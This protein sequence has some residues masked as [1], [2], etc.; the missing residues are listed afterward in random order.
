MA[1]IH[2]GRYALAVPGSGLTVVSMEG[3]AV[4]M[5]GSCT[6][7]K[8][9]QRES[10]PAI[11]DEPAVLQAEDS[12]KEKLL[13]EGAVL[14]ALAGVAAAVEVTEGAALAP[15]VCALGGVAIGAGA[16]AAGTR[17]SGSQT[18]YDRIREADPGN[19]MTGGGTGYAAG[20]SVYG[21][22]A[23]VPAMSTITGTQSG[24]M[25][26]TPDFTADAV[27]G[28]T[29]TEGY[30][31]AI[32]I[33]VYTA[34]DIDSSHSGYDV[35]LDK[36]FNK[37]ADAYEAA[38]M[39][40]DMSVRDYT[41]FG[42]R[43]PDPG[44][45]KNNSD[46]EGMLLERLSDP[47]GDENKDKKEEKKYGEIKAGRSVGK[48]NRL[49]KIFDTWRANNKGP[50][51]QDNGSAG[52]N[53]VFS[54]GSED[55][56]YSD[57]AAVTAPGSATD[58]IF[59]QST[60]N[61]DKTKFPDIYVYDGLPWKPDSNTYFFDLRKARE[62][63]WPLYEK[64]GASKGMLSSMLMS[65][66]VSTKQSKEVTY[67]GQYAA[68]IDGI[69][70]LGVGVWPA[71]WKN[72]YPEEALKTI[73]MDDI[74]A[75]WTYKMAIVVVDKGEDASDPSK[76]KYVPATRISSKADTFYGC[77]LQTNVTLDK[78]EIILSKSDSGWKDKI[79]VENVSSYGSDEA[80]IV[81]MLKDIMAKGG[82]LGDWWLHYV[83]TYNIK[84]NKEDINHNYDFAG[85]VIYG[86]TFM[87]MS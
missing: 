59:V 76:W 16:A 62:D 71:M 31:R 2:S 40:L 24:M 23:A 61:A 39:V 49:D 37:D 20:A 85:Y 28:I 22:S 41:D 68:T 21:L 14:A 32:T 57:I 80:S 82:R 64:A 17:V 27:P 26:G 67:N 74:T 19:Q 60:N 1:E 44:I 84:N 46:G 54:A 35:I 3:G 5:F 52:G 18:G 9:A 12:I 56:W 77:V 42:E 4:N 66:D 6:R 51:S 81:K 7:I 87:K 47:Y 36:L 50:D 70:A 8:T 79:S 86:D 53:I 73:Q 55:G 13:T 30:E 38:G 11:D 78:G 83:E 15:S 58:E 10:Y 25:P 63:V 33:G 65:S 43:N 29:A 45:R 75:N 72:Y 69:P 48:R 34:N